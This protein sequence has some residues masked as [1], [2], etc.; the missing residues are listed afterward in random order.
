MGR[1]RPA[2]RAVRA[3]AEPP[4]RVLS[5]ASHRRPDV[6]GL[7]RHRDPAG[8]L[9]L[10]QRDDHRHAARLRGKPGRDVDDR[11]V[12]DRLRDGAVPGPGGDRQALQSRRG[13]ALHRGAG[14][15]GR[16]L[17]PG[18]GK[19]HR[20]GGGA[21]LHHGGPRDRRVRPDQRRV[22]PPQPGARPHPVGVLAAD[23][24]DFRRRRPH[25]ALARR[26][27][28]GGRTHHA[29]RVRRLQ[30]L[31]RPARLA[32]HRARLDPRQHPARPR[33]PGARHRDPGRPG[34][35]RGVARER[36]TRRAVRGRGECAG[37]VVRGRGECG[38][39]FGAPAAEDR[40][41]R[42]SADRPVGDSP[43]RWTARGRPGR[44]AAAGRLHRVPRPDLR[45]RR[46]R[47]GP[48]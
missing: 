31:P 23:G 11:P 8:P 10:R 16:A 38:G 29:R 28:G 43:P 9:R 6:A 40:R 22:L 21:R 4:A 44:P 45:V 1:A 41:V 39:H 33:R 37:R 32:H 46:P 27:G 30:R 17:G 18:P 42:P 26:Q 15:A 5:R 3:P 19:H 34:D 20:H 12:A 47:S 7:Q 36:S 48:A 24:A 14:A 35:G 25:R 2:H 13:G